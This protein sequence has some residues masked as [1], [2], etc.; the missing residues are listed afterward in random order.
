MVLYTANQNQGAV[1]MTEVCLVRHGETDWNKAGKLQGRTDIPLN[2]SGKLQAQAC[3]NMLQQQNWDVIV[4]SPLSRAQDTAEIINT[5]LNLPLRVMPEFIERGFGDAESLTH[6]ERTEKYPNKAYPNAESTEALN[7]RL[8]DGL[9]ELN[10]D[11]PHQK[12]LLVTHGAAIHQILDFYDPDNE[13][14]RDSKLANG[15]LSNIYFYEANWHI[16][17]TNQIAHLID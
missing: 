2:E 8:V 7:R 6:I 4:T 5:Y 3:G 9:K 15:G 10:D 11:Y 1:T 12:V 17:N 16:K 14:M 13:H